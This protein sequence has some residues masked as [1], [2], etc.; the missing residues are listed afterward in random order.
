MSKKLTVQELIAQREKLAEKKSKTESLHVSSMDSDI[1]V[2]TPTK[3]LILEAQ[4][5]GQEDA[6]RADEYLIYQCV[7]EPDLKDKKLQE[8]FDCVEPMDIV[9]A[10]FLPGEVASIAEKIMG[11]GGYSIGGVSIK[12]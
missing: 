7:I 2:K 5:M 10:I 4:N 1:V 6:T 11:L 8:A 3:A 9:G 12:N